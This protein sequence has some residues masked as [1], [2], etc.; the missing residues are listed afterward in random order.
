MYTHRVLLTCL[1]L[2]ELESHIVRQEWVNFMCEFSFHFDSIAI[3][4]YVLLRDSNTIHSSTLCET[5]P[6]HTTCN[7]RRK[8]ATSTTY[9]VCVCVYLACMP[10]VQ[11]CGLYGIENWAVH[12]PCI[13]DMDTLC[14][15]TSH[16][17]THTTAPVII[18]ACLICT[19]TRNVGVGML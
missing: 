14:T 10:T 16:Q 6:E 3:I 12:V 4:L 9:L 15:G 13:S 17:A 5:M 18:P 11:G 1:Q 19:C 7:C 8:H 2:C